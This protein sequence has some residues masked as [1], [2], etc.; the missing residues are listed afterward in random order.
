MEKQISFRKMLNHL[1]L[2]EPKPPIS[3]NNSPER[4]E[5]LVWCFHDASKETYLWVDD[6]K[7]SMAKKDEKKSL[8]AGEA[9]INATIS[10]L[11]YALIQKHLDI[12]SIETSERLLREKYTYHSWLFIRL[13]LDKRISQELPIDFHCHC[14]LRHYA[15][16]DSMLQLHQGV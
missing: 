9:L 13:T 15:H 16:I 12:A 1:P 3:G 7:G 14:R 6:D 4:C 10:V 8:T 2:M 11:D 5:Y